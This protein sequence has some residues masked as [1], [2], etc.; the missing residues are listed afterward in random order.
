KEKFAFKHREGVP[1]LYDPE[2]EEFQAQLENQ[3][4]EERFKPEKQ[5]DRVYIL[6]D[7][8]DPSDSPSGNK[9]TEPTNEEL[10]CPRGHRNYAGFLTMAPN[11]TQKAQLL[12]DLLRPTREHFRYCIGFS[13]TKTE[14]DECYLC[15]HRDIQDEI[16]DLH[17]YTQ[18]EN[19]PKLI[20]ILYLDHKMLYWDS[21]WDDT[22]FGP[23][24]RLGKGVLG[25]KQTDGQMTWC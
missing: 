14:G 23:R 11:T 21:V 9:P 2:D 25:R 13:P 18:L 20:R 4:F 22:S 15:Q 12:Y 17:G 16:N 3:D 10:A 24:V 7:R 6:P 19:V 1:N 5:K 8:E